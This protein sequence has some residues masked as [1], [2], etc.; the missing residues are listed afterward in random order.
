MGRTLQQLHHSYFWGWDRRHGGGGGRGAR[1]R[2]PR[3]AA[4]PSFFFGGV[5]RP[6]GGG[7]GGWRGRL[8]ITCCE[9]HIFKFHQEFIK[10]YLKRRCQG[11][12]ACGCIMLRL[13][14]AGLSAHACDVLVC[15]C[16]CVCEE[17]GKPPDAREPVSSAGNRFSL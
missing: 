14:D 7:G 5:A 4:P 8:L 13:T 9:I 3:F 17:E 15:V 2:G 1:G 11:L 10:L 6:A 12:V 16:V